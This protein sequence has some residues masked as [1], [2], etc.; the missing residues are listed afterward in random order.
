MLVLIDWL[1]VEAWRPGFIRNNPLGK[2][3]A[4]RYYWF[5][6][7]GFCKGSVGITVVS[8]VVAGG[9]ALTR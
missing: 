5:H 2:L 6:F 9:F 8:L 7:V 4:K 3:M 1:I